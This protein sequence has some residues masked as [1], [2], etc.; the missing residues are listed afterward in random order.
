VIDLLSYFSTTVPPLPP[1]N[2]DFGVQLPNGLIFPLQAPIVTKNII[3]VRE[4]YSTLIRIVETELAV[5]QRRPG[6]IFTGPQGNGKVI[7]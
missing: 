2:E 5:A 3:F 1:T 4:C 7:L 6:V